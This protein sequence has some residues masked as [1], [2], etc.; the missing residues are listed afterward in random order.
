MSS[1]TPQRTTPQLEQSGAS[2][3][4]LQ[5]VHEHLTHKKPE[6]K[7]GYSPM[8]LALLGVMSSLILVTSI[9]FVHNVAGFDPLATDTRY[10]P[11]KGPVQATAVDPVKIGKSLYNSG[12]ACVTC[13]GPTGAGV[14]GLYPPLANS[15]WV[16]GS[17]ER[18]IRVVLHGL[19]GE[20]TVAGTK[21]AGAVAMPSFGQGGQ[22]NWS[23]ER[24][25]H[26]LTYI[27]T[28]FG[29]TGAPIAPEKVKEVREA[30]NR[31]SK[32]WTAAELESF[33]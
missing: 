6:R 7:E 14:P 26:V 15:E 5:S 17:D 27:R 21:Y 16:T 12:G 33:K 2:D 3:A 19:T 18:L 22:Y 4:S 8:P 20:I 28:D 25:A 32:P 30:A 29:N 24:V 23:D 13:H 10:V 9:F 31:G 11:S 1:R